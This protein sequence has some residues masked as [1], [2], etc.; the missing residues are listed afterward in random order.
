M[1]ENINEHNSISYRTATVA[2]IEMI[3]DSRIR[4]LLEVEGAQTDEAINSLRSRLQ[5]FLNAELGHT[6]YCWLAMCENNVAGMGCLTIRTQAGNFTIPSGK[7][8]YIMSMFTHPSHRRK[9]ISSTILK[10]LTATGNAQGVHFFEL[11][12]TP[13]GEPVYI[14]NGFRKHDEPTYRM[15]TE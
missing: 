6:F 14:K 8:G 7:I 10:N 5:L 4:F 1:P 12:A 2:D 13:L 9:G 11:H 3:I 15:R